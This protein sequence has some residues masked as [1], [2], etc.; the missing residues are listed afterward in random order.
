MEISL[1]LK[2][3]DKVIIIGDRIDLW[4]DMQGEPYNQSHCH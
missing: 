1:N 4:P 2:I 3:K